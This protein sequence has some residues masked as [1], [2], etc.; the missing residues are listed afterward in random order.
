MSG[1]SYNYLYTKRSFSEL[2]DS[3]SDLESIE[4]SLIDYGYSN[5][6]SDVRFLIDFLVSSDTVVESY[7]SYFADVFRA[8]ELFDSS[9]IDKKSMISV[10]DS[11]CSRK[12]T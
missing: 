12:I 10:L 2:I 8:V 7:S 9:D 1:G 3:L 5:I 4:K 6:A 11:Y